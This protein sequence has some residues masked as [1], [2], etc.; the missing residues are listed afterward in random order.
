MPHSGKVL[1]SLVREHGIFQF[2][3]VRPQNVL[4]PQWVHEGQFVNLLAYRG[5]QEHNALQAGRSH[6]QDCTKN[7]QLNIDIGI[8]TINSRWLPI[9]G[10]PSCVSSGIVVYYPKYSTKLL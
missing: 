9:I 6:I 3:V 2:S 7:L 10:Q 8:W 5:R 4:H 1:Y